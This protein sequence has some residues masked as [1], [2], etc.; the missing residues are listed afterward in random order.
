MVVQKA[1]I[2]ID[3]SM[4]DRGAL[5]ASAIAFLGFIMFIYQNNVISSSELNALALSTLA[6]KLAVV[7]VILSHGCSGLTKSKSNY[8]V[9]LGLQG[10]RRQLELLSPW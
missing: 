6:G 3:H 4:I 9:K 7:A 10:F 2:G 1:R 8:T 5:A